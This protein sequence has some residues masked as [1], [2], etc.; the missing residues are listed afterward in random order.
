MKHIIFTTILAM[1]T[2]ANL[3]AQ[4]PEKGRL[5][6]SCDQKGAT[7][8]VDGEM[9][10]QAP[11]VLELSGEHNIRVE[12]DIHHYYRFTK[13]H[14]FTPGAD[15][16]LS[17]VLK[18]MPPKLNVMVSAQYGFGNGDFGLMAGVCRTWGAYV[19][20]AT[21]FGS[22]KGGKEGSRVPTVNLAE[23]QLT[24]KELTDPYSMT[25]SAGVMRRISNRLYVFAGLGAYDYSPGVYNLDFQLGSRQTL[26]PY[27]TNGMCADV[28]AIFKYRALLF[29]A[30]YQAA[31]TKDGHAPEKSSW[32]NVF[33]GIGINIHKNI[34]R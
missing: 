7:V 28:G 34:K 11:M 20:F 32:G 14:Y 5:S 22:D 18:P 26:R 6:V 24:V 27:K 15:E 17:V 21:N 25:I 4:Q 10:G 1:L 9:Q 2:T 19:R 33:V 31:I 23:H 30:A 12:N 8:W 3:W 16:S 13:L 29:S